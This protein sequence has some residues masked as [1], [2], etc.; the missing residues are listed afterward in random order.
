MGNSDFPGRDHITSLF[1]KM[2]KIFGSTAHFMNDLV[3]TQ[4]KLLMLKTFDV[5][6]HFGPENLMAE[7]EK[8]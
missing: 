5:K 8:T 4:D 6:P 7:A 1:I 3:E 2:P